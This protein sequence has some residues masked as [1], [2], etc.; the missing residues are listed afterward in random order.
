MNASIAPISGPPGR[1]VTLQTIGVAGAY[2]GVPASG[3]TSI[4]VVD[5]GI[6]DAAVCASAHAHEIGS[7]TW[8]SG[9]GRLTFS[10]PALP[11]GS[12]SFRALIPDS[13][14]W[15]VGGNSAPLALQI[16]DASPGSNDSWLLAAAVVI[17][18]GLGLLVLRRR[19]QG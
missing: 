19:R 18:A 14:C 12:Y 2:D 10:I 4:L 6:T 15:I 3:T 11:A 7:L 13:G 9:V 5:P 16:D 17:A 8:T 1:T